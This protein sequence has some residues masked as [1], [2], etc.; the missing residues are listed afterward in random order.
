MVNNSLSTPESSGNKK[1]K[2]NLKKINWQGTI[3]LTLT[4][5]LSLILV[6]LYIYKFGFHWGEL[7]VLA[8]FYVIFN[9]SIT[10]GYHRYFSHRSY[11]AN[12][13]LK[14][15]YVFFGSGAVQGSILE[16][17]TDHRRH[18]LKVDTDLDPYSIKKGFWHAHFWWMFFIDENRT[19]EWPKD[20]ASSKLIMNQHKYY[21]I[22]AAVSGFILPGIV[23]HFIGIG[24]WSGLLFGGLLRVVLTQHST[25]L[26]NSLAHTLGSQP[27]STSHTA[28]DSLFVAILTFGEGYH[29]YHHEFQS[30]YRAAVKW[31]QWDPSKWVIRSLWVM[32]LV[33]KLKK[34][35]DVDI[36]M[37]KL[38]IESQTLSSQGKWDE[39]IQAM[40]LRVEEAQK[41]MK[42]KM[43][44]Y[45]RM[46]AQKTEEYREKFMVIKTELQLAKLE[47]K[48]NYRQ[49][50]IY[51]KSLRA[52]RI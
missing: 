46:K 25:F 19:G 7:A 31:Y 5:L 10:C 17:C 9:M 42:L 22:W 4:P 39:K 23:G 50:L 13:F 37:A 51:A 21:G 29:N 45:Q 52:V 6:P 2:N 16:W 24:F 43:G 44:E 1:L 35:S 34:F 26:V 47:F 15:L 30:D 49:F 12:S 11:E 40:K 33:K 27:Y 38:R 28:R 8:I 32:R 36:M 14:F 3:F 20:L 18:H 48:Y 41:H